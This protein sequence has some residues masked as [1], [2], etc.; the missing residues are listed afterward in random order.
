MVIATWWWNGD[1]SDSLHN[2][3]NPIESDSFWNYY[4]QINA[5]STKDCENIDNA[6]W[7]VTEVLVGYVP[8]L[9]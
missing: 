5:Y 9:N 4:V 3:L 7:S 6:L 1:Y 2:F 8:T